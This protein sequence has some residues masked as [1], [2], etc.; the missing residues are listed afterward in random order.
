MLPTIKILGM[1]ILIQNFALLSERVKYE[2]EQELIK[3]GID[4]ENRAKGLCPVITG[5]LRA[6]TTTNWSRSGVTRRQPSKRVKNSGANDGIGMPT[7]KGFQ[8]AT[9]TNVIY[10]EPVHRRTPYLRAAYNEIERMYIKKLE[11]GFK[12]GIKIKR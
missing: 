6:S 5:R 9:G 11:A 4:F 12:R 7:G 10:A 3:M 2:T 8:V 1:G